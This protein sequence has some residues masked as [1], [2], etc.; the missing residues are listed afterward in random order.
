MFKNKAAK[1]D[2]YDAIRPWK[3]NDT[4]QA[5]KQIF[6]NES[7]AKECTFTP[8]TGSKAGART[9]KLAQSLHPGIANMYGEN[10]VGLDKWLSRLGRNATGRNPMLFKTGVLHQA[11]LAFKKGQPIKA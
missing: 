4:Y 7:D 10:E 2:N 1:L 11:K 9:Q 3:R 6:M 8:K 5:K